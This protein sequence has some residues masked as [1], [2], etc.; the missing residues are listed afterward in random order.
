MIRFQGEYSKDSARALARRNIIV[1]SCIAWGLTLLVA[2]FFFFAPGATQSVLMKI[3]FTNVT[4]LAVFVTAGQLIY[5]KTNKKWKSVCIEI[6]DGV[7]FLD[8]NVARI[9][10][11]VDDVK[12]VKDYGSYYVIDFMFPSK[13]IDF[14]CEKALLVEGSIEEFEKIFVDYIEVKY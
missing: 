7:L 6:E 9:T 14:I 12:R 5:Y 11:S 4:I 3:V 8:N 2:L 13:S 1:M 10:R